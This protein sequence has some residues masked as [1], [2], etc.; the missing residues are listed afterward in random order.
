MICL[1]DDDKIHYEWHSLHNNT[2]RNLSF[3]DVTDATD[4]TTTLGDTD[5]DD[6]TSL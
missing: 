1:T 4:D 2:V 6:D 3:E 5:V